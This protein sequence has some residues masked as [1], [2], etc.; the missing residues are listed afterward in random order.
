MRFGN[1]HDGLT[2]DQKYF[3]FLK[4]VLPFKC[5]FCKQISENC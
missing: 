3:I 2:F 1:I 5:E 4:S